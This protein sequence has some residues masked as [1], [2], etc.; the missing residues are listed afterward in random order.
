MVEKDPEREGSANRVPRVALVALHNVR[1][2]GSVLQTLATQELIEE[3]GAQCSVVDF[4]REGTGDDAASG[5]AGSRCARTP[6]APQVYSTLQ[7]RE[8]RRRSLVFRDFLRRRVHL[9]SGRYSS[10]DDLDRLPVDDYDVYCVGSDQVWNIER[11]RDNRPFYL[12]FLPEETRRFSF[13]SSIGMAALPESEE[14][15]AREELSRFSGLSVGEARAYDYLMS[16]GLRV[17]QHVDPTLAVSAGFWGRVAS[18]PVERGRT[19][20]STSSIATRCS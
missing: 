5:S 13:A 2:Y 4:R 6:L 8:V 1:N 14:R 9:T 18:A 17:E 10:F 20:P 15:R 3:A 11:N 12:S 19:S 7:G 16:L